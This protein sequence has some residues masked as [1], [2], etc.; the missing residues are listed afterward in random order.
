M[1]REPYES[2][3]AV[4]DTMLSQIA[5]RSPEAKVYSPRD[6]FCDATACRAI[7]DNAF[8]Y[9]SCD[10]LTIQGADLVVD[11]LLRKDPPELN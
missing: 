2:R 1:A 5:A 6:L 8:L 3:V 7:K 11:D 10:H 9:Y 4:F